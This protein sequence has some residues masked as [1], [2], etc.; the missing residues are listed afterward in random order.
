MNLDTTDRQWYTINN[1][2]KLDSPAL[3]IYPDRVKKNIETIVKMID[4]P[5]RLR[6]HVKTHKT[7]EVTLLMIAAGINKFKCATIAEAEMLGMCNAQDVL[8]AY[9]PNGPKI[10]RFISVIK[11]YPGTKFSCLAD[12]LKSA[13][14][15]SGQAIINELRIP[16]YIDLNVGMNRTG[17]KP[18]SAAMQLYEDA[19]HLKGLET[20][21]FHAYD[22]HIHERDIEI[23]KKLSEQLFAPIEKLKE[24]LE[25]KGYSAPKL[26]IGGSPT[27][28]IYA[29]NPDVECSPG[30]FVF[31]D[32]G[33]QDLLPEQNFLPAALILSRVISM[34]DETKICL[35]LGH[36]SVAAENDLQK[37]LY[38]LN[39]PDLK[40]ISQ[41]EEHLVLEAGEHHQW[42]IGDILY[43][44]PFHVCPT[45]ALY[46]YA[47]LIE[48][49]ELSGTWKIIARDRKITI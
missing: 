43:A 39:A 24:E 45:C 9:Q 8:L 26:V 3:I 16:V 34:P 5:A 21:G 17:I 10:T 20:L 28:P 22:G 30:T 37:R 2:D 33:Y 42:K 49:G 11:A 32:K 23:R 7:K 29:E 12:N 27:F 15:I 1:P 13:E 4:D 6:P 36:K 38:F 19:S 46:E 31:W 18:G 47:T 41:S 48:E 35:D 25:N 14:E 40:L 44:L